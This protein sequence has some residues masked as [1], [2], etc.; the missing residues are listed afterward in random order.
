[1]CIVVAL[2]YYLTGAS[3]YILP[4]VAVI[5]TALLL[6]LVMAAQSRYNASHSKPS[7][8][9]ELVFDMIAWTG[10][11]YF[12]GGV[13]NP[14]IF[15][16]LPYVAIGAAILPAIQAW[17]YGLLTVTAYTLLWLYNHKIDIVGVAEFEHLHLLG[18]W[19]TFA[20]SV[21]VSIW[22]I[23][24]MT[25]TIQKYNSELKAAS[26]K[27]L[28]DEWIVSLGGFAASTAHE[29]STPLSTL[30]T[31]VEE[32]S[33]LPEPVSITRS[34]L[35]LM[36]SQLMVCRHAL[37]R[38]TQQAN[39][40]CP[41]TIKS[42]PA[43]EW[44]YRLL[45]VWR[46]LHPD[47]EIR[48]ELESRLSQCYLLPDITVEQAL[49][50]LVDNAIAVHPVGI[51]LS[52]YCINEKIEINIIDHGPGMQQN[53]LAYLEQGLPQVSQKGLGLGLALAK[54]AVERYGGKMEFSNLPKGG[55]VAKVILP[56]D[57]VTENEF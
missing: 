42:C 34:D 18:M 32:M 12:S 46:T 37:R 31:L 7:L 57:E 47:T 20:I 50:N 14:I 45:D 38:L 53:I 6:N 52:A 27:V 51:M 5:I 29:L 3:G 28:R 13:N 39:I 15:I 24:R 26:E 21:V 43:D 22:F 33:D 4:L 41:D 23:T 44:L 10:F 49:R 40:S 11:L 16:L 9:M 2:I 19:L 48:M 1:M 36:D 35:E 55:T 54:S 8:M 17:I 56:V 25:L 30:S